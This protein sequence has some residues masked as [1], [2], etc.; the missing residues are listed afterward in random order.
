MKLTILD[1]GHFHAALVQKSMYA[2]VDAEVDVFAPAGPDLDDYL[3]KIAA[4]NAR[5]Q[6]PTRWRLQTHVGPDFLE[7]FAG[8]KGAGVVVIAGN[9]LRKAEYITRAIEAGYHTLADK[10][11]AIDAAGFAALEAAFERAREK[12]VLLYDIMT[13]RHE[14]TTILQKEFSRIAPLFGA[15]VPGDVELPAVTKESVHHFSKHVS[16][17]PI[18][19]PGWFFDT[20]QQGEGLVDITTHLVDL[21]QWECFPEQVLDYRRDV[22]ILRARRWPTVITPAQFEQVTQLRAFPE[23]LRRDVRAD[24]NLYVH[25]NGEID[26]TLRGVHAKV[27]VLWNFEAPAGGGDT[28]FSVMRGTRANLVIRQ[29]AAEGHQPT[30]YLEAV[31]GADGAAFAAAAEAALADAAGEI[32][33]DR[34]AAQRRRLAGHG[35]RV[36]SRRPRSAFR[37]G[38]QAVSRLRGEARAAGLGGAQHAGQVLDDDAGAGASRVLSAAVRHSP[39]RLADCAFRKKSDGKFYSSRGFGRRQRACRSTENSLSQCRQ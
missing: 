19:R 38:G 6:D 31:Q 3:Q 11:M 21:V 25:A 37:A 7:R 27:S 24:G 10:P 18:K 33:G 35:S 13:E 22:K 28:H 26:Y 16:G 14:I 34:V 30:L 5:A 17:A 23:Y 9:N 29:G 20:A 12:G 1:P 8:G 4:Y 2:E 36:V 15:L 32:P 39:P